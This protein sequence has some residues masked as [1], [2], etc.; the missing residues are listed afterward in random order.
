MH[1][2]K[3][4]V[5]VSPSIGQRG[6]EWLRM[7]TSQPLEQVL[8]GPSILPPL[9]AAI[10][11]MKFTVV[12]PPFECKIKLVVSDIN[13]NF[14]CRKFVNS[15]CLKMAKLNRIH[16]HSAAISPVAG[17]AVIGPF[18]GNPLS[19]VFVHYTIW[20]DCLIAQYS[21]NRILLQC[22]LNILGEK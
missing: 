18:M 16:W 17:C 14:L 1:T 5:K 19:A 8:P 10:K 12:L 20:F 2:V 11:G 4:T 15:K 22:K 13:I 21:D 7:R 6:S 3:I 9:E